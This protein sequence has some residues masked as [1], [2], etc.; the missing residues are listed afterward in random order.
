MQSRRIVVSVCIPIAA[1][2]A[3]AAATEIIAIDIVAS[4]VRRRRAQ[5]AETQPG[6]VIM[7]VDDFAEEEVLRDL[8]IENPFELSAPARPAS[9]RR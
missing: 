1:M 2:R 6:P 8:G 5:Q 4:P 7:R 9:D 3:A